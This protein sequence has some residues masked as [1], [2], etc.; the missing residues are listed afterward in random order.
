M[1]RSLTRFCS[2]RYAIAFHAFQVKLG[3]LNWWAGAAV[4]TAGA[5][6]NV[7][8]VILS[9]VALNT[10]KWGA[11]ACALMALDLATPV[12]KIG[13]LL[14]ISGARSSS[15]AYE[16]WDIMITLVCVC[17]TGVAV[18][19]AA[20]SATQLEK[21]VSMMHPKDRRPVIFFM[22]LLGGMLAYWVMVAR[23]RLRT[24]GGSAVADG[25]SRAEWLKKKKE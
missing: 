25:T 16:L 20:K 23:R 21:E 7:V 14:K 13:W 10:G 24:L 5:Y 22:T 1:E 3:L 2:D 15:V 12:L 9:A 17:R 18:M 8:M 19:V 4:D 11:L 6:E